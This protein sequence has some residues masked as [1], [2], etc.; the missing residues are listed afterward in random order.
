VRCSNCQVEGHD[1]AQCQE[2]YEQ[3]Q[4]NW[5]RPN[6]G[7]WV[8]PTREKGHKEQMTSKISDLSL[9]RTNSQAAPRPGPSQTSG[10]SR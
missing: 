6:L 4:E 8:T 1:A 3:E 5:V 9:I 10:S 7:P 2:Y